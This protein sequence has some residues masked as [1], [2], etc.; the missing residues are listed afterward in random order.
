M[1]VSIVKLIF[2]L[3][4]DKILGEGVFEG[5]ANCF[6]AGPPMDEKPAVFR[7]TAQNKEL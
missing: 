5:K 1:Q 6:R 7:G 2:L 4:S 3:F